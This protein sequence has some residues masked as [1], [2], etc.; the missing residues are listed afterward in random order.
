M[1]SAGEKTCKQERMREGISHK[2][3]APRLVTVEHLRAQ[4]AMISSERASA[5]ITKKAANELSM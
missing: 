1:C 3:L 2:S 5:A 4:E